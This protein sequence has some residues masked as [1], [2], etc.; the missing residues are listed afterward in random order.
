[1]HYSLVS[2]R[3]DRR[4]GR[5]GDEAERLD[6]SVLLAGCDKSAARACSWPRRGSTSPR[7]SSTPVRRCPGRLD[8]RGR[9]DHRRVR[10]GRRVRRRAD[11]REPRSTRSSARSARARAPAAACTP[12]TRWPRRPRRWACR[13]RARQRRPPSTGGAT[14]TPRR[15][16]EA[17]VGLLR[18]GH[19]R[20]RRSSPRR[21]FENAIAVVMALGGST[22]AV[23]HLL[24]IAHEARHRPRPRRLQPHRR[25]GAAPGRRQA[26]RPV[27]HDRR[28]QVGGVPV[29]M[30]ALLDAGL[31]HGDCLTV[32]G[33]TMAREPGRRR[34]TRPRR[35]DHPR[36][37]RP[38][39]PHRWADDPARLARTRGCRGQ[40][41]RLRPG[42]VR[43]HRAGLRRRA[44][45][46]G[47]RRGR[48]AAAERRRG[49]PLRGPQG[50]SRA[51]ARCSRS[52]AP[53]RAPASARTC[54]CSPTAGSPA[55]RPA[56]ASVTSRPRP[57][58]AGPIAFVRDGDR[59]R[60]DVA[61]RRLDLLVDEAELATRRA[62]WVAAASRSYTRG[63]LAK[64]ARLVG[65]ARH[66]AVCD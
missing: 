34:A 24:A 33:E 61:A 6:G 29:V 21:R 42:R 35:Q 53:S 66:G 55:V 52:P 9:H 49:D 22:N 60:L 27:R 63:V 39:P 28:R 36:D 54:C 50:R 59:I 3:G 65:S 62:G 19:H 44:R 2:P 13:C 14:T 41:R 31:L 47:R 17:V 11:H 5:D 12:P 46:D 1:M 43:G 37:G 32:T 56:C 57:S 16:G 15:S 18:A 30:K 58:T 48:R 7:C 64:Y 51:C 20:P 38:D 4:L 26:V 45:R 10:G 8:G 25:Q 40:D 23:L